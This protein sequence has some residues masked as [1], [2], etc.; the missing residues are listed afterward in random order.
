MKNRRNLKPFL[1][2]SIT[3]QTV[4]QILMII[5]GSILLFFEEKLHSFEIPVK[6]HKITFG[7]IGEFMI[8][9]SI[10]WLLGRI[11]LIKEI[12]P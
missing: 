4:G 10:L 6:R 9:L 11:S 1:D 12:I 2:R 7:Q 5:L 3:Y 8:I